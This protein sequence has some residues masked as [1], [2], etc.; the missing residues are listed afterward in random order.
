MLSSV[1]KLSTSV[2]AAA[3]CGKLETLRIASDGYS[4]VGLHAV[5]ALTINCSWEAGRNR[6]SGKPITMEALET[7]GSLRPVVG[8]HI[9]FSWPS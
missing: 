6:R 3:L 1:G 4:S 7:N 9:C 5:R 8:E 2:A